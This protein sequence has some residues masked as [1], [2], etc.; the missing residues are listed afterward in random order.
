MKDKLKEVHLSFMQNLVKEASVFFYNLHTFCENYEKKLVAGNTGLPKTPKKKKKIK[1][2]NK[3]MNYYKEQA[4]KLK[5]KKKYQGLD[6]RQ[7]S[8]II[9]K[10]WKK[11][12]VDQ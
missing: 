3:Y 1:K 2:P 12:S 5:K 11:L 9:S 4:V 6:G 8:K 7:L 10:K